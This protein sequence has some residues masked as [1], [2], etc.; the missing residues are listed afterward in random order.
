MSSSARIGI[1][2][3]SIFNRGGDASQES[4]GSEGK[5]LHGA[6]WILHDILHTP[7]FFGTRLEQSLSE[8][9]RIID[10]IECYECFHLVDACDEALRADD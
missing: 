5:A 1:P 7:D 8:L 4:G 2:L 9:L 6:K 3:G 10:F